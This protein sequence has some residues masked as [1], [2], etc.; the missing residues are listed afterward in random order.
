MVRSL[1]S[2]AGLR[3]CIEGGTLLAASR[4]IPGFADSMTVCMAV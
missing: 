1:K 3:A 4:A 2:D